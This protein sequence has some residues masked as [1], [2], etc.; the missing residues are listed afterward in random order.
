MCPTTLAGGAGFTPS[1][2]VTEIG[3]KSWNEFPR[4]PGELMTSAQGS[5]LTCCPRKEGWVH[6]VA[7]TFPEHARGAKQQR[8]GASRETQESGPS[9]SFATT[10]AKGN[11]ALV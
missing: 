11:W 1:S 5:A 10:N 8:S 9:V 4:V 3:T 2:Q 6:P 7:A